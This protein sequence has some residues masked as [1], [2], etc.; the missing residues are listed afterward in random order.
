M[1]FSMSRA[2][3]D[4]T[5]PEGSLLLG[6]STKTVRRY[7]KQGLLEKRLVQGKY[8]PEIR[9]SKKSL[10]DL[11]KRMSKA[12]KPADDPYEVLQ[13]YR[14][15]SPD[16]KELVR[17]ILTSSPESDGSGVKKGLLRPFFWKR[18]EEKP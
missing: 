13:L 3:K 7:I 12:S 14:K 16:V 11:L 5:V 15:A 6:R 18:G 1:Y 10:D 17:K 9:I 2:K 4:F 8:G